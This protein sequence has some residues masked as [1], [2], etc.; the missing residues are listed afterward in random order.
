MTC[1]TCDTLRQALSPMEDRAF[2]LKY[3]AAQPVD[4]LISQ[5]EAGHHRTTLGMLWDR[6]WPDTRPNT[7][8][9][10]KLGRTLDAL[11]WR[12]TKY[13]GLLYFVIPTTLTTEI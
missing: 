1:P 13:N 3:L 8:E 12:R 5:R 4:Y 10:T 6:T 7:L 9:L 11:G 2:T